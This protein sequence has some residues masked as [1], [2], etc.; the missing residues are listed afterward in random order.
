VGATNGDC[1]NVVG[2]QLRRHYTTKCTSKAVAKL[3]FD[4]VAPTEGHA[5]G[6]AG[7]CRPIQGNIAIGSRSYSFQKYHKDHQR[8]ESKGF[9]TTL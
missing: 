2:N 4:I 5:K 9:T 3:A 8:P 1:T 7:M 6:V